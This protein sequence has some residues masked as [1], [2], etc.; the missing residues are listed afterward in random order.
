[1]GIVIDRLVE[2]R[3]RETRIL[4]DTM[5]MMAQMGILPGQESG[6]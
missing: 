2:G 4:M 3:I 1:V 6:D 5:G